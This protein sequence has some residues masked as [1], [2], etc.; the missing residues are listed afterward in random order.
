MRGEDDTS[1]SSS[2]GASKRGPKHQLQPPTL[3]P[4]GVQYSIHELPRAI[5]RELALVLPGIGLDGLLVVPTCQRAVMDLVNVGPDVAAQKD[6][7][8]EKASN[9]GRSCY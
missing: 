7:L 6:W 3:L 2:E 1:A 9:G 5:S 4:N 8:L